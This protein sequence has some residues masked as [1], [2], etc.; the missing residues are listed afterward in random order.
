MPRTVRNPKIDTRT[1]RA[2][3]KPRREPYWTA[4]T[5][6]CAL[7]YRRGKTGGTWIARRYDAKTT[8]KL[9]HCSLGAADDA[10]DPDAAAAF[11]FAQAQEKARAW[12][13]QQ[14]LAARG[15]GPNN[16]G[17]YT[18]GD[19]LDDYLRK[20]THEGKA[21][22]RGSHY[23]ADAL[24]R[25][26][27]GKIELPELTAERLRRFLR[28]LADTPARL[29]SKTGAKPRFREA[30]DTAEATRAR[31]SSAN[32]TWSVL[33]AALNLAF[34]EGKIES[35]TAWR[36]VKP[37]QGADAARVRYLSVEEAQRLINA[38]SPSFR[39]LV[40]AALTTGA[41]FGELAQLDVG[42]FDPDAG[43][44]TIRQ[45]KTGR[46]RHIFLTDEGK[47]IFTRFTA[48]RERL[49]PMLPKTDG[50]RWAKSHQRRPMA[51]ACQAAKID[52]PIGFHGLRH[53]YASLAVMR[54]APLPVVAHNLGHTSV[55][56]VEKHYGHLAP[57]YLAE[58][59]RE[60]A[61]TFGIQRD[62]KVIQMRQGRQA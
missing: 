40:I 9:R 11:S 56:M 39:D 29:R 20:L 47:R 15:R 52:P 30:P 36:R 19:A 48:G 12:F 55:R 3:L 49:A 31:R 28:D 5:P 26:E 54:G 60:T 61:P 58:K 34:A 21:S 16:H 59:T 33:R 4:I 62:G 51:Q 8:P 7:G 6:G 37:F 43:T 17:L 41:R 18:V 27:L 25:P 45:S 22:A 2:K 46:A 53:T 42:D 44:V 14:A 24:I 10:L 13:S 38:S 35:D 32:R 50:T 1:A 23:C 57:S